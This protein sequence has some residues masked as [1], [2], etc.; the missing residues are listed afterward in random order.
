ML[1]P[2]FVDRLSYFNCMSETNKIMS[3]L[4]AID[5]NPLQHLV[6][7]NMEVESGML[8]STEQQAISPLSK[9]Q[10]NYAKIH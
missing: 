5:L 6:T 10:M 4:F 7:Y 8:N 1:Y 2:F 9:I 3:M